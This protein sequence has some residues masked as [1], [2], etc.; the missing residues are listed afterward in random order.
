MKCNNDITVRQ[1]NTLDSSPNHET[2]GGFC[3]YSSEFM[4]SGMRVC[5][6]S[7][8]DFGIVFNLM[9]IT[10]LEPPEF[11]LEIPKKTLEIIL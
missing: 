1:N 7:V 11:T 2:P 6:L 5:S 9:Q 8:D 4:V 3:I 10:W